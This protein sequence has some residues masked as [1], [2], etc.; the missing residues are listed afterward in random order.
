MLTFG[1]I[2][3]RLASET[4]RFMLLLVLVFQISLAALIEVTILFIFYELHV[5]YTRYFSI[6]QKV[7][8]F[9]LPSF[10]TL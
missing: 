3:A 7:E 4:L 9:R 10:D 6:V 1:T 2:L 5:N 8:N